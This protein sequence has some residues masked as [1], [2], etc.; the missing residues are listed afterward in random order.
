MIQKIESVTDKILLVTGAAGDIGLN[1]AKYF[2]A[3]GASIAMTDLNEEKLV[4]A[5]NVVEKLGGRVKT[6]VCDVTDFQ[7]VQ[8]MV[9]SVA[10]DFGKIDFLF[11][12]AGY[13]GIFKPIHQYPVDDFETTIKVNVLGA[14]NVLQVVAAHMVER[15]SGCIVNTASMAGVDGPPNMPAYG[16]SKFA[17]VGLTQSAAKD[18]APHGIRVNSIS[19]AFMGPGFM[20]DRQV[21]LQAEAGSQYFS[22]D[23]KIVAEQMI[24][25]VPMRRYGDISEIPPVVAFLLGDDSSYIT[26]VNIPISGGIV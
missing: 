17:I 24:G 19:P 21:E 13:Q 15:K 4:T 12:N 2:A 10:E 18:L 26:G 8:A 16:A 23:P 9:A 14:F 11:N 20:W 22:T 1:T 25:S 6:Y 3:L 7:G 5:G